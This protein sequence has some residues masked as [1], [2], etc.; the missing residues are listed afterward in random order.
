MLPYKLTAALKVN[1]KKTKEM[2]LLGNDHEIF[3]VGRHS[4]F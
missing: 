1:E 3:A 4:S 2:E